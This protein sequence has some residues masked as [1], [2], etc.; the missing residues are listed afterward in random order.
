MAIDELIAEGDRVAV[1]ATVSGTH[2]GEFMGMP[3]SGRAF[4]LGA[5]EVFEVKDG[6]ITA[7]WGV[8]DRAGLMEQL[9]LAPEM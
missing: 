2:E 7:R 3:P 5:V 1:Q 8:P 9:G 6:K 4:N